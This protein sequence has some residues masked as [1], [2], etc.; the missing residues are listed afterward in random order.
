M[1]SGQ[2]QLLRQASLPGAKVALAAAPRLRRVGRNHLDAQLAQ[3]PS[4]LRQP[5]RIHFA[6]TFGVNQK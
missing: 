4:H 3:R 2:P 5:I 6:P 1:D